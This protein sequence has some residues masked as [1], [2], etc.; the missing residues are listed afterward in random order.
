[1]VDTTTE[2]FTLTFELLELMAVRETLGPLA[3]P[4]EARTVIWLVDRGEGT[5][6]WVL[7]DS[8]TVA[9]VRTECEPG[10]EVV[11]PI[12]PALLAEMCSLA[13]D[14]DRATLRLVPED[15]T[16]VA[17]AGDIHVCVDHL[18]DLDLDEDTLAAV[19]AWVD[20]AL[21][22]PSH[23]AVSP[24]R[25]SHRPRDFSRRSSNA[26]DCRAGSARRSGWRCATSSGGR[27]SRLSRSS[28]CPWPR[29]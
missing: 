15:A 18:A 13:T 20:V 1:M 27:C 6:L 23:R 26:S 24:D 4:T 9:W 3:R 11:V 22:R 28:A 25:S 14:H 8:G 19:N 2:A 16:L 29:G 17:A 10:D 5:R 12:E 21:D 7:E